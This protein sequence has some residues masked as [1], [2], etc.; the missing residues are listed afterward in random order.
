MSEMTGAEIEGLVDEQP[1]AVTQAE[2]AI[3]AL[4]DDGGFIDLGDAGLENN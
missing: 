4:D 3:P 1:D 2:V